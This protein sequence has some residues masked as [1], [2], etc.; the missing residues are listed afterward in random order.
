MCS[1][2]S[3]V[4]LI[5]EFS[6]NFLLYSLSLH[7]VCINLTPILRIELCL[8]CIAGWGQISYFLFNSPFRVCAR[9]RVFGSTCSS[10]FSSS[11]YLNPYFLHSPLNP[12]S[13]IA[14]TRSLGI[15]YHFLFSSI[16]RAF[17][18]ISV[19][20]LTFFRSYTTLYT[21]G[22]TQTSSNKL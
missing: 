22:H 18:F 11:R 19:A 4:F 2:N 16:Q 6:F 20:F 5:L 17:T 15:F 10:V 8:L 21:R 14:Y 12:A 9:A 3:G 1:Y 13:D 7:T